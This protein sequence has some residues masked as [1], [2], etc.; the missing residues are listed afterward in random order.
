MTASQRVRLVAIGAAGI[1]GVSALVALASDVF[2]DVPS[3]AY[4]H[5][6]VNTLLNAGITA[7]CGGTNYCPNRPVTRGEMALFLDRLGALGENRDPVVDARSVNGHALDSTIALFI[8]PGSDPVN[9]AVV[10]A[11]APFGSYSVHYTV[12]DTPGGITPAEVNVQLV[13]GPDP[14]DQYQVCFGT[15]DGTDLPGGTYL[16]YLILTKFVEQGVFG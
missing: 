11:N 3:N 9:C 5:D 4:Y 1:L 2:T 6:E 14:D 8:L 13:D 7:G 12:F 16:A 10:D 15:L